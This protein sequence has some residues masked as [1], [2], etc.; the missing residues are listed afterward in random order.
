M[1]AIALMSASIL[2]DVIDVYRYF[3]TYN[4][5]YDQRAT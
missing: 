3:L 1:I 2:L 5:T 4:K